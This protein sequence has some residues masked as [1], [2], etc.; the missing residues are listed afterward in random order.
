MRLSQCQRP[1]EVIAVSRIRGTQ[2]IQEDTEGHHELG[3]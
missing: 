1:V 2:G 3:D